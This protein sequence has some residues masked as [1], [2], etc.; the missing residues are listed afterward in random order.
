MPTPRLLAVL[1]LTAGALA[2]AS[3]PA[4]AGPPWISIELP[5]NPLDPTTRGAFLLIHTFHHRR[6]EAKRSPAEGMV[7]GR[8]QTM[9][10]PSRGHLGQACAR[11]GSPGPTA[12]PGC[13][14]RTGQHGEPRPWSAS[15]PTDRPLDQR[16]DRK[17][18]VTSCRAR[19]RRRMLTRCWRG[20][21]RAMAPGR[22]QSGV[23]L[24][25]FARPLRPV[26]WHSA[27]A[28]P[29]DLTTPPLSRGWR[30]LF[31]RLTRPP[32]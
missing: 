8:R 2:G 20:W 5:A 17:R 3:T 19:C 18:E 16:T 29:H 13:W 9:R 1:A 6:D 21:R 25:G 27:A 24:A 7:N 28:D 26:C 11:S 31:R 23:A 12:A 32:D 10:S 15:G 4:H 14:S 22:A 30:A